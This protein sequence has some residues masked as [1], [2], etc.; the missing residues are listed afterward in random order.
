[1]AWALAA[2]LAALASGC[3]S[4]H[5]EQTGNEGGGSSESSGGAT[6]LGGV[7]SFGGRG[8]NG[9]SASLGG[10]DGDGG[11][12]SLGGRRGSGGGSALGG[13]A[14]GGSSASGGGAT[15]AKGGTSSAGGAACAEGAL[16]ASVGKDHIL[17]GASMSDES[18]QAAPFDLRYL[19][20]SGGFP[21]GAGPCA[22]CDSGCATD[23]QSCANNGNGCAWWGCWQYD[24]DPPGFYVRDFIAK[25]SARQQVPMLTWYQILQAGGSSEGAAEVK[26]ANDVRFMARYYA[27]FKFVLAQI[28]NNAAFLHVEPDF[29]GYGQQQNGDPSAIAAAVASA[30]PADCGTLP[31]TLAGMGECLIVMTRRYAPNTKVGLHA[32]GWAT[33]IDVIRNSNPK[34]DVAAEGQ[35]LGQFLA[36]AGPSADFIVADIDDRDAAYWESQGRDTWLDATNET[37]P[38][39]RQLFGWATALAEAA[40]KPILWWQVPVGNMS[41]PNTKQAWRDNCVDYLMTHLDEVQAA[42]G[43]GVAF[44]AGDGNTTTPETDG[45][46]LISLV[47]AYAAAPHSVCR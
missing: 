41:L 22:R 17:I 15:T 16:L 42:H 31:N 5:S 26:K 6:S 43:L 18:A 47:K 46:H 33:G 44:G 40:H 32:S 25:S 11:A 19:Y 34:L 8:G 28:G 4:T 20:L 21:D 45:G 24:Q 2:L 29:W 12:A 37:L 9:G 38:N 14:G 30:N 35:K 1:M 27:N 13:R 39:F 23:G 10:R 36:K 7:A 3:S